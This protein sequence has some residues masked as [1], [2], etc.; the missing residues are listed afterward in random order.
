MT[1]QPGQARISKV[2]QDE[3]DKAIA[4]MIVVDVLPFSF[5]EN[6]GFRLLLHLLRPNYEAPSRATVTKLVNSLYETER[7]K[8]MNFCKEQAKYLTYTTDLWK[9]AAKE[10]YI[11]VAVHF[12]DDDWCLHS[13][14][15]ATKHVAGNYL[16][17]FLF[18][19]LFFSF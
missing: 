6:E 16:F 18:F 2:K 13:P 10:Y 11:S 12:I 1:K 5:V 19:I 4:S 3:I 8:L 17:L 15:L 9:S 14:L 7:R